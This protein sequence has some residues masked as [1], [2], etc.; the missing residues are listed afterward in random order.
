MWDGY[1]TAA[2]D[3]LGRSK[4]AAAFEQGAHMSLDEA[5]AYSRRGRRRHKRAPTG[6]R[7]LS[8]VEEQVARLAAGGRSNV[9]IAEELFISRSTVKS[10]LS[11]I[12][13]KVGV[14]NRIELARVASGWSA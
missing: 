13:A 1:I 7:G 12:Y 14:A 8:P 2:D 6:W 4:F 5:A 11:H 9:E 3:A 10:H